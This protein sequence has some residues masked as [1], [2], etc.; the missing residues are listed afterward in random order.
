VEE[1]KEECEDVEAK[2]KKK[3]TG[4]FFFCRLIVIPQKK[5]GVRILKKIQT[6]TS[7]ITFLRKKSFY[8]VVLLLRV[9]ELPLTAHSKKTN[10]QKQ[11]WE[12]RYLD[13][14]LTGESKKTIRNV[15]WVWNLSLIRIPNS[16]PK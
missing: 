11:K 16:P 6:W 12:T 3:V 1:K 13:I 10:K 15:F 9:N 7:S 14:G 4:T 2:N 5:R 8:C